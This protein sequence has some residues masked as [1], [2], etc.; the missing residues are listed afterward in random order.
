MT[1][2]KSPLKEGRTF[3]QGAFILYG[4]FRK[5]AFTDLTTTLMCLFKTLFL[6]QLIQVSAAVAQITHGAIGVQFV[7]QVQVHV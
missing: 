2:A 5:L 6:L 1:Y 3:L 4:W 7:Q